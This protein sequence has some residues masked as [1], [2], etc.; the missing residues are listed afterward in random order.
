MS[1]FREAAAAHAAAVDEVYGES[2]KV[3]PQRPGGDLSA[4]GDDPDRP[5]IDEVIGTV[6]RRPLLVERRGFAS[7]TQENAKL[8]GAIW[9]VGFAA[10]LGLDLRAGD[11]VVRLDEP[12]QPTLRLAPALPIT[13][14]VLHPADEVDPSL[15]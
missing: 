5:V 6:T 14:R 2:L 15:T 7:R 12:G 4:G 13:G 1:P 10:A 11:L 8:A 3:R 9:Q